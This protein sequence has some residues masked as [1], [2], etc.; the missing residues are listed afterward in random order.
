MRFIRQT[1]LLGKNSMKKLAKTNIAIIGLGSIGS[2]LSEILARSG[3]MKLTLVDMDFVDEENLDNQNFNESD[4]GLAKVEAVEN[5]I[6]KI[7]SNV[8]IKKF[9]NE[10]NFRNI[11]RIL[12]NADIIVDATDNMDTKLLLNEFSVK[13]KKPFFYT[14][15]AKSKAHVFGVINGKACL[16]CFIRKP[17]ILETCELHGLFNPITHFVSSIQAS[18]IINYVL[19]KKSP[20]FIIADLLNFEILESE[21]K[22]NKNC[23]CCVKKRF[24][25]INGKNY[26]N[27]IRICSNSF[28][29]NTGKKIDLSKFGKAKSKFVFHYKKGNITLSIFHDGRIIVKGVKDQSQAAKIISKFVF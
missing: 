2:F 14:S 11:S 28:Q 21:V 1:K 24:E 4:I 25:Y 3:F 26:K 20:K 5:R 22:K 19:Y 27:I 23:D 6:K 18:N 15:I 13:T 16:K 10:I 8:N 12:E 9:A 7:N 29:I 17:E